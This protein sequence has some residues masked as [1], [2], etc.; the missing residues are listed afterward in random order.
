MPLA[1]ELLEI[2]RCPKCV[3]VLAEREGAG[4]VCENCRLIY[5]IVDEIPS[6]L[7]EEARPLE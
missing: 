7:V 4:L 3:G 5:P 2:L 6:F 1:P